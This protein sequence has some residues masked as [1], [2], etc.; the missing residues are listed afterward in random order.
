MI[1]TH[2]P[3][4]CRKR[5]NAIHRRPPVEPLSARLFRL[6]IERGYSIDDLAKE[7]GVLPSAVRCL[8][9]GKP[10]DKRIM[11][12]LA[13]AL[14]VPLCRLVC[15]EHDCTARACVVIASSG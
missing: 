8:E 3:S 1:T 13:R 4:P 9:S 10:A 12:A 11:Q 5:C 14:G 2:P 7:A 6:R 15:G